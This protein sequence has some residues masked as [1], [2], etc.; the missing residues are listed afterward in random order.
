MENFLI[1]MRNIH[2]KFPGVYALNNVNFSIKKGEILGLMG[3]NG[4]GKSTLMKILTGVYHADQGEIFMEGKKLL[5]KDTRDTYEHGIS[6]IFQELN[7][8]PNLTAVENIFLGK[9]INLIKPFILDYSKMKKITKDFFKKLNLDAD[10]DLKLSELSVA[11]QQMVEIAKALS[12]NVKLLIMDEPTSALS[13]KEITNLFKIIKE[14][15][16]QGVSIVFISHKLNEVLSITD[17]IFVLRDGQN[18]GE[19]VSKD[20]DQETIVSHMVGREL[21]HFFTPRKK[22]YQGEVVFEIK[23]LSGTPNIKNVSFQLHKGEILG[24]AGLMGSGRTETAR[25][26]FGA[27]KKSSG[28]ILL[29][30]RVIKINSPT[31]AIRNKITYLSED[32]K[33]QSLILPM[34]V[35]ENITMCIHKLITNLLNVIN[36][37]K[38]KDIVIKYIENL[39]IKI[40][41]LDQKVENLSGGN[42]QKV[43]ISKGLSTEP[44]VL[45]LDEPT[46]GIDVYAKSEVHKIISTLADE[47]VSIILISSE[48]PEI[49]GLADNIIVMHEGE[50]AAKMDKKDANQE[51]IL[52][53]ALI[54]KKNN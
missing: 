7:N 34:N 28:E 18:V 8:C 14:L 12:Y 42:Q 3:E 32:R 45:I 36:R 44:S 40:S 51:N 16:E 25:L 53:A 30:G 27:E 10:P 50:I 43:V 21:S 22:R 47:G 35:R 1:E 24:F 46:R 38:E 2:K 5:L 20:S 9:E 37:K 29:N 39:S 54:N 11:K 26:I 17:R 31:D 49:L 41:G 19:L 4:A 15:K 13:E 23:N 52:S 48:L 33:I 6:I